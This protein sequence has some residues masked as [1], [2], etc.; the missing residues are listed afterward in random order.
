M[1]NLE[2]HLQVAWRRLILYPLL[3]ETDLGSDCV[4]PNPRPGRLASDLEQ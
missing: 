3:T 2:S 4:Y 1:E